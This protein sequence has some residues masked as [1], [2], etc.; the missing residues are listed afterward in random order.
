MRFLC[1]T[2]CLRAVPCRKRCSLCS[3]PRL[4][5]PSFTDKS[6]ESKS[7]FRHW[8]GRHRDLF[9]FLFPWL[10]L[11]FL[12]ARIFYAPQSGG[13]WIKEAFGRLFCARGHPQQGPASVLCPVHFVGPFCATT[14]KTEKEMTSFFF[15]SAGGKPKRKAQQR[16]NP[17]RP[18]VVRATVMVGVVAPRPLPKSHTQRK[19]IRPRTMVHGGRSCRRQGQRRPRC[20]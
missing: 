14:P 20:P 6:T 3:R 2:G 19:T 15:L 17:E 4:R 18:I 5:S 16:E 9:F 13:A 12:Q 7:F 11:F 1:G 10:V 8:L